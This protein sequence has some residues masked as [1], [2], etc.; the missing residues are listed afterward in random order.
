MLT[1]KSPMMYA[2]IVVRDHMALGFA[3]PNLSKSICYWHSPFEARGSLLQLLW[4]GC[5]LVL[6]ASQRQLFVSQAHGGMAASL[7]HFFTNDLSG[8][9]SLLGTCPSVE[10]LWLKLW[11]IEAAQ[12]LKDIKVASTHRPSLAR[13]QVRSNLKH[14]SPSLQ[15]ARRFPRLK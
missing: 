2:C 9:L 6:V 15:K 10:T 4:V 7:T 1:K 11:I 3:W 13:Y 14:P 5:V 8:E 12:L